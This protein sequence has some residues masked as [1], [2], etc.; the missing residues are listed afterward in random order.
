MQDPHEVV[1]GAADAPAAASVD[2]PA[3]AGVL[4]RRGRVERGLSVEQC[5]VAIRA[6]TAQ[7]EALERGDLS[8]FGGAVYARGFLRSLALLVR[9]DPEEVLRLHGEDPSFR[10]PILPPREPL[11]LRREPPGWL[12]GLLGVVAVAG[13]VVAVLGLGGTR[14]PPA[15]TPSDPSIDAPDEPGAGGPEPAPGPAEPTPAPPE[16]PAGPPIDLVI[17]FEEASWLEV[18][19]DDLPAEGVPASGRTVPAGE[20][21]RFV[22]QEQVALRFGNAGGVRIEFNGEDLGAPGRR[23]EVLRLVFSPD[24]S[25]VDTTS[26]G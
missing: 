5:A 23:G 9:V 15:A 12:V 21:L 13:V 10:G 4:L 1:D 18:L 7:I 19:V 2:G 14:V 6:R 25:S 16:E 26:S 24:G 3:A 17:T 8:G 22:G 11:R 20:T